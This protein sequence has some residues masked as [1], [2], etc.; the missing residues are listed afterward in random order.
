MDFNDYQKKAEEFDCFSK[1]AEL[2]NRGGT[3]G[4]STR[5]NGGSW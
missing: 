3:F 2:T 1:P 5:F 4:K